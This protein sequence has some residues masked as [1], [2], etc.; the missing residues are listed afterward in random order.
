MFNKYYD[1][2]TGKY[3]TNPN[4]TEILRLD[5]MLNEAGI[6]H[7]LHRMFDGFQVC[8]P[9]NNRESDI[10][11]DA[12]QHY[13]SYGNAG[14]KLE[15]MGLLT[16]E[17]E[18]CD[19]VLG[20]LTAEEVFERI[21]KHH[22][23]EQTYTED[24]PEEPPSDTSSVIHMTPEEFTTEMQK[25]YDTYYVKKDDEEEAHIVMDGIMC[26]F[27]RQLGYGEGIDIFNKTPKWYA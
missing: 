21:R 14:N 13:G 4:Y 23:G 12:I 5:E 11:M 10:V 9:T 22:V 6:P 1:P 24:S 15:I 18:E 7:T 25:A 19:S 2:S 20:Y 17:E 16:P 8:Y 3:F 27:L 26:N